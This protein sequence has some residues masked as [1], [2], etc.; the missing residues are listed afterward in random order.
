MNARL[1]WR[2]TDG[3]W[4]VSDDI[5]V[6]PGW[7]TISIDLTGFTPNRLVEGG[8]T[9]GWA[10]QQIDVIRFDPHEDSGTRRFTVASVTLADDERPTNGSYEISFRDRA[11]KSRSTAEVSLSRSPDGSN[12]QHIETITDISRKT[13]FDW[14]V[15]TAYVGTGDWYVVVE[16]CLLYTSDAADE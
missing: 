14:T 6:F 2:T 16:I 4:R 1:A 9:Q 15:P 3:V 13:D 12:P 7:N 5:V 11:F 10:G 8:A